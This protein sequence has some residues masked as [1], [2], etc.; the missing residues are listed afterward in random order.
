MYVILIFWFLVFF[1]PSVIARLTLKIL[2]Y[3]PWTRSEL[4]IPP[5]KVVSDD[6][7]EHSH[8]FDYSEYFGDTP[9]W[10]LFTLL[11]Q[12]FLAFPAYLFSTSLAK[13]TI[14]NGKRLYCSPRSE[15]IR[16]GY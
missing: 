15:C 3:V 12:Q 5:E 8:E 11:R 16:Y 7:A 4:G 6:G 14:Q 10:T 2:S 13:G 1:L 9:L